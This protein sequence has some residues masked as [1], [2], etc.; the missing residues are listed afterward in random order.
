MDDNNLDVLVNTLQD[1]Q[2]EL[3]RIGNSL[4]ILA[5]NP[6][7]H[8]NSYGGIEEKLRKIASFLEDIS[9]KR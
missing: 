2:M 5:H 8:G 3:N 4:H 1:I 9:Y 6:P 7:S